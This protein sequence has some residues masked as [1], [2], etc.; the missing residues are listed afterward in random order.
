MALGRAIARSREPKR[1]QMHEHVVHEQ[2][3]VDRR[4]NGGTLHTGTGTIP[5]TGDGGHLDGRGDL[6]WPGRVFG[7]RAGLPLAA[8]A[9]REEET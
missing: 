5:S 2:M 6:G 1:E 7:P 3:S 8:F 4:C 9:I